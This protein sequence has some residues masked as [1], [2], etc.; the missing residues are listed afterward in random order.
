MLVSTDVSESQSEEDVPESLSEED[1]VPESLSEEDDVPESLSDACCAN[2][3]RFFF[4]GEF[5]AMTV[6]SSLLRTK[7][8]TSE[9]HWM[10]LTE[11]DSSNL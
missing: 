9:N 8:I 5:I 2:I 4:P 1:D 6:Q 10:T 7:I 11:E 3:R